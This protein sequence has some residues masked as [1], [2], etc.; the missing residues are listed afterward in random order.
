MSAL[1][2]GKHVVVVGG[3]HFGHGGS[4][5]EQPSAY[6]QWYRVRLDGGQTVL[7]APN[8]LAAVTP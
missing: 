1:P 8:D 5:T 7:V 3:Q 4:V 2:I 6:P